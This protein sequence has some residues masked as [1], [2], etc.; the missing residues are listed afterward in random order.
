MTGPLGNGFLVFEDIEVWF[1]DS[2]AS[3]HMIG[4]RLVFSSLLEID[5]DCWVAVGT[6]PQLTM[7]GVG[8][9]RFQLESGGF[10][11]VSELLYIPELIV[12][13]LLV[14]SLD[15]SGFGVVFYDGHA[16]LYSMGATADTLVMLGVKYEG[17]YRFLG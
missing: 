16:F 12:D 2:E 5:S 10:L 9:V 8:S 1:L 14:S 4:M 15:E 17:L 7:K 11:E 6:G 13:F 3:Q